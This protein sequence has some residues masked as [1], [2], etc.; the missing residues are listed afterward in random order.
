MSQT[1]PAD[2]KNRSLHFLSR[3]LPLHDKPFMRNMPR[4]EIKALQHQFD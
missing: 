4:T 3:P 1:K 2:L